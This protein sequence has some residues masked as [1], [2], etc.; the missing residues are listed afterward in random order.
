VVKNAYNIQVRQLKGQC[1][2][3]DEVQ[4]ESKGKVVHMHGMKAYGGMQI[5]VHAAR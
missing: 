1:H 5:Q 3:G 4:A 2:W